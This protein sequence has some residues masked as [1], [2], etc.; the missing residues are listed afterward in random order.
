MIN[1]ALR[2]FTGHTA[3]DFNTKG[4]YFVLSNITVNLAE[5]CSIITANDQG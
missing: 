4:L 2:N 5:D 3:I 1:S